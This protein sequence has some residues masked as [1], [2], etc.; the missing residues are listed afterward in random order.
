MKDSRLTTVLYSAFSKD[1]ALLIVISSIWLITWVAS[2]EN[3]MA[4]TEWLWLYEPD[5]A[6]F[7]IWQ[8][9]SYVLCCGDI[10]NLSLNLLILI[11]LGH[12][13]IVRLGYKKCLTLILFTSILSALLFWLFNALEDKS[14]IASGGSIISYL[15]L[16]TCIFLYPGLRIKIRPLHIS[17]KLSRIG[18]CYVVL[19]TMLFVPRQHPGFHFAAIVGPLICSYT[20]IRYWKYSGRFYLHSKWI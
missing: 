12:P 16:F 5:S 19:Q 1:Y 14:V 20:F 8:P 6:S 15:M 9:I 13:V 11:F 10:S 4:I 18:L 2:I 17:T 3:E 7:H